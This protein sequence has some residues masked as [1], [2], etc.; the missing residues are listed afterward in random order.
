MSYEGF[1]IGRLKFVVVGGLK[2]LVSKFE[3]VKILYK[4]FVFEWLKS[5]IY[6]SF[7]RNCFY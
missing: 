1:V 5:S 6:F 2:R 3:N 7:I 4:L